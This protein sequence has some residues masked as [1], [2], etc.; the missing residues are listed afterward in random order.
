MLLRSE[1]DGVM[2]IGQASHAWV[3]GQLARA[4]DGLG[5]LREEVCLAAEQHDVAWVDWDLRP[6]VNPETGLPYSFLEIPF[7]ERLA[8]WDGAPSKLVTQSA[9]AAL[10]VSLHGTRLHHG[11]PRATAY[12]AAQEAAQERWLE[13]TG[14]DRETALAHRDLLARWDGLSLALCLRWD[15]FEDRGLTLARVADETFTLDPW[16]LTVPELEVRCEGR[17]L[18]GRYA[19]AAALQDALRAAPLETLRFTLRPA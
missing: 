18:T 4:W 5:A 2:C 16:P 15:P 9:Y 6:D 14:A 7:D 3:S 13:K 10:L 1:G 12:L 19:D 11:D 8:L 17:P